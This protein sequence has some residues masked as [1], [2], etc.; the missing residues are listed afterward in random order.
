MLNVKTP[1]KKRSEMD[2]IATTCR[3]RV[4]LN[5]VVYVSSQVATDMLHKKLTMRMEQNVFA[6]LKGKKYDLL[7]AL[8]EDA[9]Q[10]PNHYMKSSLDYLEV[11]YA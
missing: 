4:E 7:T 5:R 3:I 9:R 8:T 2:T 11:E 10:R 1:T 6:P